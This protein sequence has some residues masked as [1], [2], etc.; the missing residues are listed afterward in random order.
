MRQ[1]NT[2]ILNIIFIFTFLAS[3]SGTIFSVEATLTISEIAFHGSGDETCNGEDWVELINRNNDG[4]ATT[5]DLTDYILHD[6]NGAADGIAFPEGT[7]LEAGEYLIVCRNQD[8]SF[9]IGRNDIV[10][11]LDAN[12]EIVDSVELKGDSPESSLS[13]YAYFEGDFMYTTV[14]TPGE[15]NVFYPA[16][17]DDAAVREDFF[18]LG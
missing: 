16:L 17:D 4:G 6:D 7:L 12:G 9:G 3:Y 1:T 8:F 18:F 11:L 15:D 10:T 5:V 13:T 14:M 2:P